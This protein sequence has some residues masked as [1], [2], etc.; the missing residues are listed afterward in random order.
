MVF[1]CPNASM[2]QNSAR[3]V[4]PMTTENRATP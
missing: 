2:A 3:P 1:L 4:T